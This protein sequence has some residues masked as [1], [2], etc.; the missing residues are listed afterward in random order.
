VVHLQVELKMPQQKTTT[1]GN[2]KLH[3]QVLLAKTISCTRH[4]ICVHQM[5]D[6]QSLVLVRFHQYQ[7]CAVATEEA[8]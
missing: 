8:W 1:I 4:L 6:G 3:H 2:K 5:K 7:L